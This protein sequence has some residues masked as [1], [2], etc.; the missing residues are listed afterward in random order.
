MKLCGPILRGCCR[1]HGL[2]RYAYGRRAGLSAATVIYQVGR[3]RGFLRCTLRAGAPGRGEVSRLFLRSPSDPDGRAAGDDTCGSLQRR[4]GGAS[5][6]GR[7]P[8]LR[9]A[10]L[11][12]PA[13]LR[14][15]A[16][17]R[18]DAKGGGWCLTR[19]PCV[20][21]RNG[22]DKSNKNPKTTLTSINKNIVYGHCCPVNALVLS[23]SRQMHG[24]QL[25]LR[26]FPWQPDPSFSA[27]R[28]PRP[29]WQ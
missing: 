8:V 25:F 4:G 16:P 19:V 9:S 21:N 28:A 24:I 10:G 12:L 6:A 29:F 1:S 15:P 23:N 22:K 27:P 7:S 14:E 18:T 5:S 13:R 17:R 20:E 3:R 26:R 2:H 11:Q